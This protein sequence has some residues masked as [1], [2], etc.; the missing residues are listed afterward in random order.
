MQEEIEK[1]EEV[2]RVYRISEELQRRG[3][4]VTYGGQI[5]QAVQLLQ[6]D[7]ELRRKMQ[8]RFRYIL[9]D[10]FQDTN[11]AQI[12]LLWLLSEDH[13]NIFVVGDHNQAIYRFRGASFGSFRIRGAILRR[14]AGRYGHRASMVKLGINYRSTPN[15]LRAPAR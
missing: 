9:V 6:S 2:A 15:I 11:I 13:R 1:Q 8:E 7:A 12:E 14:A 4:L 3:H 5:F 10:E